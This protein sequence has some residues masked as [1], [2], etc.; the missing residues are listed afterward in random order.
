MANFA[1]ASRYAKSIFE[2]AIEKNVLSEVHA[3]FHSL[4]SILEESK[5]LSNVLKSPII[6]GDRK[7][8]ILKAIFDSK[9][10]ALTVMFFELM[11]KKGREKY[12]YDIAKHFH[13]MYNESKGIIK[14]IFISAFALDQSTVEQIQQ[15]LKT[16]L[17]AEIETETKI[18]SAL[19]AG[20]KIELNDKLYD[21][22]LQ[23]KLKKVRQELTNSQFSK[24]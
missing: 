16:Q 22:S 4:I 18:D 24:N 9:F 14:A 19:I 17:K 1:I 11:V 3:D 7:L 5:E 20:F 12:L 2:L 15:V 10:N 8:S 23:S 13:A 21:A 6:S